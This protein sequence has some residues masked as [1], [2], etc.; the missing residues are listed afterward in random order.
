MATGLRRRL[1]L[2]VADL[3][4]HLAEQ[5]VYHPDTKPQN[6]LV[7]EEAGGFALWLVDLDRVRFARPLT[8][9]HWVKSLARINSG[10]NAD[11][12]LLDRMRCLRECSRGR[13]NGAERLQIARDVHAMSLTRDY[14]WRE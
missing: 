14:A 12:S 4:S 5:E 13:W 1:G 7:R 11:V 2:A 6:I 9:T 8:R 3:L 10:L